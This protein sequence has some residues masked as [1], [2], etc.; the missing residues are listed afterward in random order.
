MDGKENLPKKRKLGKEMGVSDS[1]LEDGKN[2]KDYASKVVRERDRE[3]GKYQC[4]D[5]QDGVKRENR[6]MQMIEGFARYEGQW[7]VK[8]GYRDGK[9]IQVWADGSMYEG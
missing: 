1:F 6:P 4:R 7:S 5:V 8:E 2:I 3:L 9:G